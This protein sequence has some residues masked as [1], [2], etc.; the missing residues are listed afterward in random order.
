MNVEI[1]TENLIFIFWEYLFRNFGILS[2]QCRAL[3]DKHVSAGNWTRAACI[4]DEEH[5]S[6][7]L[8]KQLMLLLFG[9][10]V[11]V[12]GC[13]SVWHSYTPLGA[14]AHMQDHQDKHC[15]YKYGAS[16]ERKFICRIIRISIAFTSDAP[17]ISGN[18]KSACLT[19]VRVTTMKRPDKGHLHPLTRA[20]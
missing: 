14:K 1:G 11:H 7:E 17:W 9:Y 16:K 18:C 10:S 8:F 6:K 19:L 13:P 4:T 3:R 15:F 2:L 12:H 5:T 20:P